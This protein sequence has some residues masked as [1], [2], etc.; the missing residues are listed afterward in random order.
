MPE[1]I[2]Y[3]EKNRNQIEAMIKKGENRAFIRCITY[4][5]IGNVLSEVDNRLSVIPKKYQT[6]ITINVDA[7]AQSFTS[8]YKGIPESTKFEAIRTSSGWKLTRVYRDK[9]RGC[10]QKIQ[11]K[12]TQEA[13]EALIA[14]FENKGGEHEKV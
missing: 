8:A 13:K 2:L 9:C 5:G 11:M 10:T 14:A 3:K 6:G 12:L 4:E 1:G 7:N